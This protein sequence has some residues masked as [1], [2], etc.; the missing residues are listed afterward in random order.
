MTNGFNHGRT[1]INTDPERVFIRVHP[2]S[3]VVEI[4][5][6]LLACISLQA[7]EKHIVLIAGKPSHGPGE[8]EFRAGSLLLK[9]C[10]DQVPGISSVVY[11]NGWP[12][13]ENALKRYE[14]D[15]NHWP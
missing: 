12:N 8:H 11:S 14:R 6:L 7:A 3:S 4:L 13:V 9:K 2:C 1:R 5:V 10:L 15:S